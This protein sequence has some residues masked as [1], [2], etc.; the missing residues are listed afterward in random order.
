MENNSFNYFWELDIAH[1]REFIK[2][3]II[4][5]TLCPFCKKGNISLRNYNIINNSILGKFNYYKC[6]R[7]IYLRNGDIFNN[8]QNTDIFVKRKKCN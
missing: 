7:N 6:T 2:K 8:L 5:P 4:L 3:Y 1:E